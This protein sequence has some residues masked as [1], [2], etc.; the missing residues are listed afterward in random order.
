MSKNSECVLNYKEHFSIIELQTCMS[1]LKEN[2]SKHPAEITLK[3]LIKLVEIIVLKDVSHKEEYLIDLMELKL[4]LN[5]TIFNTYKLYADKLPT[6]S[7][8]SSL[9]EKVEEYVQ[10]C[11]RQE[12]CKN[13]KTFDESTF[14]RDAFP[15]IFD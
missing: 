12:D 6:S 1:L 15:G 10:E 8:S 13:R 11:Q 7:S 2:Y 4:E 14:A 3:E 5:H 9:T